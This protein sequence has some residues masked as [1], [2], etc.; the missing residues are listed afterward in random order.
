VMRG[1][2]WGEWGGVE[3]GGVADGVSHAEITAA[4]CVTSQVIE[5]TGP[6]A[7]ALPAAAERGGGQQGAMGATG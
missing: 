4:A 6:S 1:V 7:A 5:P 3:W 2:G